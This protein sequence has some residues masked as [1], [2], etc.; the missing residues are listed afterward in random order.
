MLSVTWASCSRKN[1]T[2]LS[3]KS[4][5]GRVAAMGTTAGDKGEAIHGLLE[6]EGTSSSLSLLVMIGDDLGDE[7]FLGDP[8]GDTRGESGREVQG[9]SGSFRRQKP[10]CLK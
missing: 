9:S 7:R 3:N 1:A 5:G 8:G 10:F 4:R 6:T 2:S